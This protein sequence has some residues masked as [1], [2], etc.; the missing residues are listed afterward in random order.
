MGPSFLALN[1]EKTDFD[2]ASYVVIP[3][4]YDGTSTWIKGADRGPDAIIRASAHL[5]LYDMETERECYT[6]GIHTAP[7]I[8]VEGGPECWTAAVADAA[9]CVFDA[10][11]VPIVLGGEH[12]VS[13]GSALAAASRFQKLTVLQLDA[14]ADL[15]ESLE[16]SRYNHGCVMARIGEQVPIIQTGIRSM[17]SEELPRF[18][19]NRAVTAE[20]VSSGKKWINKICSLLT[21]DTY[22]TIDLDVFDPS[23]IPSTGTPEPGGLNWYQV[24]GLLREVCRCSRVIGFD[25]VELCPGQDHA[26]NFTAAKLIYTLISY[27]EENRT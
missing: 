19:P 10:G 1:G 20:E 9:G 13:I 25:V 6:A 18:Q 27:M 7:V 24:T 16:G 3:V 15:R 8:R 5:E 17:S 4:P 11:K 22:I 2:N 23:V 14:H 21:E 12:S 26:S